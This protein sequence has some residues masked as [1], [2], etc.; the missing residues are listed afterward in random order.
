MRRK[1][2]IF[3]FSVFMA[4]FSGCASSKMQPVSVE[5]QEKYP[6]AEKTEVF[7]TN[8][9]SEIVYSEIR[10]WVL[11]TYKDTSLV[12]SQS[13]ANLISFYISRGGIE[14][15]KSAYPAKLEYNVT[16]EFRDNRIRVASRNVRLLGYSSF[17]WGEMMT[18]DMGVGSS[19]PGAE[20]LRKN[21][22]AVYQESVSELFET[23]HNIA[24]GKLESVQW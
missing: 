11:D 10:S 3:A 20:V 22:S 13:T 18:H 7:T 15:L 12:G 14:W 17:G 16:I 1:I 6:L 9:S 19:Y 21:G 23:I 4:I 2:H 24:D 8:R 5:W